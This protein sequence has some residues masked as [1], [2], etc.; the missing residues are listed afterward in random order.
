[1]SFMLTFI[2]VGTRVHGKNIKYRNNIYNNRDNDND[3]DVA[4]DNDNV[5]DLTIAT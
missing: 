4:N 1:M 3:N 5:S 2:V